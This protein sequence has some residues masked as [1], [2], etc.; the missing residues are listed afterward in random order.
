MNEAGKGKGGLG[1]W[2]KRGCLG[3]VLAFIVISV[4]VALD[5]YLQRM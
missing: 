1:S 5:A 4:L 2:I 3:I